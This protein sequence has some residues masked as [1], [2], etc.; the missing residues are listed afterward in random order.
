[1]NRDVVR[2]VRQRSQE[3][4]EYCHLP[5]AVYPLPFHV[6]HVIARQHG[7]LTILENLALAYL[8][9]NKHKGPNIAGTDP[10]TSE[11]TRLFH[12]RTD[13]WNEHF[14]WRGATLAG[15]TTIGRT[16]IHAL[17]INDPDFVSVRE[18]LIREQTFLIE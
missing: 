8:H 1:M 13:S 14:E 16:T 11:L 12:P 4:C 5:V 7:G 17:A 10:N 15:R 9:C 6:D 18:A 2:E 3:R